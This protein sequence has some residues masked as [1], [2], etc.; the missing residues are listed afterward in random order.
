MDQWTSGQKGRPL[1]TPKNYL[2][3]KGRML[4][5][6]PNIIANRRTAKGRTCHLYT[7][8][9]PYQPSI[10]P[11]PYLE[12]LS[13]TLYFFAAVSI[14]FQA[15]R[16]S[17]SVTP[18]TWLKRAAALRTC[19]AFSRGSLRCLGKANFVVGMRSRAVSFSF[20]M[21]FPP[22]LLGRARSSRGWRG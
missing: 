16:R 14:R 7:A 2:R 19:E 11:K 20:A 15:A 5:V 6:T 4:L 10:S 1:V 8:P 18:S 13:S 12:L 9:L 3:A 21:A 17:A 22:C